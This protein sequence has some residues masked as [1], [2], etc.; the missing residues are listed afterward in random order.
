MEDP[1]PKTIANDE[2]REIKE[3]RLLECSSN[4]WDGE[5]YQVGQSIRCAR[6]HLDSKAVCLPRL[7]HS[8]L[9]CYL[10]REPASLKL[11]VPIIIQ[12]HGTI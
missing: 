8:S 1:N 4:V 11:S 9:M 12:E 10:E 3:K 2:L 6:C 5:D 7:S